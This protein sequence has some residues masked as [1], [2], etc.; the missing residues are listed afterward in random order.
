MDSHISDLRQRALLS[1]HRALVGEVDSNILAITAEIS[2]KEIHLRVFVEGELPDDQIEN[3]D[4]GVI[5]EIIADFPF[6][7]SGDPKVSFEFLTVRIKD[8]LNYLEGLVYLK[9]KSE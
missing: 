5:T 2:Q 6:P 7:D 8:R 3:F 1:I 4:A 9:K